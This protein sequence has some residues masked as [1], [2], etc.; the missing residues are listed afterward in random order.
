MFR[1]MGQNASRWANHV[2]PSTTEQCRWHGTRRPLKCRRPARWPLVPCGG[3]P[4]SGT[5]PHSATREVRP[6][7]LNWGP[8][9]SAPPPLS[10]PST[11]PPSPDATRHRRCHR[12]AAVRCGAWGDG[13]RRSHCLL[14]LPYLPAGAIC[15]S[16]TMIATRALRS[17]A[18]FRTLSLASAHRPPPAL[19]PP[20]YVGAAAVAARFM[21]ATASPTTTSRPPTSPLTPTAADAKVRISRHWGLGGVGGTG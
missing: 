10:R 21:A 4:Q 13:D 7:G 16:P 14:S 3:Q 8:R 5:A 12:C 17:A 20:A 9:R 11:P 18:A 6:R 2:S 15:R 19:T 1:A